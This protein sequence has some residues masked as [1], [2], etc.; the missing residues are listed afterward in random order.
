MTDLVVLPGLDGT[1]TL[2]SAFVNSV[3]AEF[4]S[5]TVVSYPRDKVLDYSELEAF[6]RAALPL[7][8]PFVLLGESFSGPIALS[9][10]AKPPSGLVGLVLSTSFAKSPIPLFSPLAS[11][12]RFAPVRA[13][14]LPLLS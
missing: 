11:F 14:P 8:R 2:R 12:A 10:A 1:A 5:I 7:D 4:D 6:A 3:A 9:I 13:L